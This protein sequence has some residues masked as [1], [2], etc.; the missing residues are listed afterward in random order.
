[1][2]LPRYLNALKYKSL[3]YKASKDKSVSR[4]EPAPEREIFSKPG[5]PIVAPDPLQ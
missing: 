2:S 1:M 5:S 4:Q 3:K